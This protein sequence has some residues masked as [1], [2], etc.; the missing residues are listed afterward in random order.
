MASG[1]FKENK[2][3]SYELHDVDPKDRRYNI[4]HIIQRSDV[5][6]KPEFAD[7]DVDKVSNLTPVLKTDHQRINEMI[8][9]VEGYAR[10]VQERK[11]KK[12]RRGHK[13]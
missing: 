6:T 7:F 9:S 5:K 13:R 10:P 3:R 4:H 2:L 12:K 11:S 8:A 1:R